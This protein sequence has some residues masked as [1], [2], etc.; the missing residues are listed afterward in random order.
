LLSLGAGK[1][2]FHKEVRM[3]LVS[4]RSCPG[5]GGKGA[6]LL[7]RLRANSGGG[8]HFVTGSSVSVRKRVFEKLRR[9]TM[10]E[11]LRISW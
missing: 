6:H 1:K 4:F 9:T 7:Q 10:E 8:K 5:G 11:K 3:A 2:G